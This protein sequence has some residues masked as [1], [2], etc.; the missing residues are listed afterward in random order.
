MKSLERISTLRMMTINQVH[1]TMD[2]VS[3]MILA[4]V[5]DLLMTII[6]TDMM[7]KETKIKRWILIPKSKI[8]LQTWIKIKNM[9]QLNVTDIVNP[10]SML[11]YC[12]KDTMIKRETLMNRT[13]MAKVK[14]LDNRESTNHLV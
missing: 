1:L 5:E 7:M 4:M 2:Q 12:L 9:V 13:L 11:T 3:I 6:I 10:R 8:S 14:S